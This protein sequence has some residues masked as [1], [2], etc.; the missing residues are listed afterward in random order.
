MG[1]MLTSLKVVSMAVVCVACNRRSATRA[2]NRD[3]G[4]RFCGRSSVISA[5]PGVDMVGCTGSSGASTGCFATTGASCCASTC[6]CTSLLVSCPCLPVAVICSGLR[7]WSAISLRAAG[8]GRFC[9][10][11]PLTGADSCAVLSATF[12]VSWP[13]PFA[14]INPMTWSA[15]TVSPSV[16]RI[17]SSTPSSGAGTSSITL[18]VSISTSASS[19]RIT[20]PGCL[21]QQA[22]T[23]SLTDSGRAGTFTSV[24][25]ASPDPVPC[26]PAQPAAAHADWHNLPRGQTV[27]GDQY[28]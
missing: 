21:C 7:S 16:N 2:R 26:S 6:A 3:I 10:L 13:A 27:P 17:F 11:P 5:R 1:C 23:P 9:S 28:R 19:R 14:P 12:L 20:S 24:V 8:P 25:M 18:S 15:V 4:T 22:T